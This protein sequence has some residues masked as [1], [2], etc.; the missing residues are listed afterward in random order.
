MD[1]NYYWRKTTTTW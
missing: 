1:L